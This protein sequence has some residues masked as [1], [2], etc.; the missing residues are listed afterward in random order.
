LTWVKN[1]T[2]ALLSQHA[3]RIKELDIV[4][5]DPGVKG[6]ER[7]KIRQRRLRALKS[8]ESCLSDLDTINNALV[9]LDARINVPVFLHTEAIAQY[10]PPFLNYNMPLHAMPASR[11]DRAPSMAESWTSSTS[12]GWESPGQY[13]WSLVEQNYLPSQPNQ[14]MNSVTDTGMSDVGSSYQGSVLSEP[15]ELLPELENTDNSILSTCLDNP[16][17]D[18]SPTLPSATENSGT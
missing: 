18:N 5:S 9:Q 1:N 10:F 17:E 15:F 6:K 8:Q 11:G 14:W 16:T 13:S 4:L 2:S 7:K 12:S 3:T